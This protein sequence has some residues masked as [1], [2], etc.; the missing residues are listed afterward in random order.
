MSLGMLRG[1]RDPFGVVIVPEFASGKDI[2]AIV[3]AVA[4]I[5]VVDCRGGR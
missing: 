4:G 5:E 3:P 1:G 2:A